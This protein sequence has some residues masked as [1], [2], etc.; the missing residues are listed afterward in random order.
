MTMRNLLDHPNVASSVVVQLGCEKSQA[1]VVFGEQRVVPLKGLVEPAGDRIP[2]LTIQENSGTWE[3]VEQIVEYVEKVLL[4]AADRRRRTLIPASDLIVAMQCGGSDAASGLTANP[5]IGTASDLLVRCGASPF[6]S[7]TTETFGAEHLF[8]RRAA[9]K[10]IADRYF[11]F[12]DS[13]QA[14]LATGGGTPQHNLSYGNQERGLTT[15]AEKSLGAIAKAGTT[16]LRWVVDYGERI[17]APG[18][19]FMNGPAFDPASAT[20]QTAGGAQVGVFSTGSGSCFGGILAPWIKVVSNTETYERMIDME[21][22]AGG[23]LDGT[24]TI[25]RV[26]RQ[27][28]E[29]ILAAAGGAA[30]YSEKSGYEVVN[31]WDSGTVT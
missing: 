5:A 29:S 27:I 23:I 7:E 31:I 11:G 4:P 26:G 9:T 15:I 1:G 19:G 22:N 17:E 28:F 18:L 20:G 30:T 10:A 8:A 6:I 16:A 25:E 12:V 21:V 3:T 14:Y 2:Y 24:A 13:Y